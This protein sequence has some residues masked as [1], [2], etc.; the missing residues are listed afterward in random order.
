MEAFGRNIYYKGVGKVSELLKKTVELLETKETCDTGLSK[1]LDNLVNRASSLRGETRSHNFNRKVSQ[2]EMNTEERIDLEANAFARSTR[3]SRAPIGAPPG[4]TKGG[5]S[6]GSPPGRIT[7]DQQASEFTFNVSGETTSTPDR[8]EEVRTEV[9][10]QPATSTRSS[11]TGT[12]LETEGDRSSDSWSNDASYE[13][14]TRASFFIKLA[15]YEARIVEGNDKKRA[16]LNFKYPEGD[17]KTLQE[18]RK[19][20]PDL[21]FVSGELDEFREFDQK[22]Y[23]HNNALQFYDQRIYDLQ[24][25]PETCVEPLE[26]GQA[27][28]W[29]AEPLHA[30]STTHRKRDGYED[31]TQEPI[32]RNGNRR[33]KRRKQKRFAIRKRL[34]REQ[35]ERDHGQQSLDHPEQ[36]LPPCPSQRQQHGTSHQEERSHEE[37]N[38]N[39]TGFHSAT[40]GGASGAPPGCITVERSCSLPLG[41]TQDDQTNAEN[42]YAPQTGNESPTVP[43]TGTTGSTGS[44]GPLTDLPKPTVHLTNEKVSCTEA[45]DTHLPQD[46]ME[47]QA[48][49][50]MFDEAGVGHDAPKIIAENTSI[51]GEDSG[52]HED[53]EINTEEET[54][55]TNGTKMP[56]VYKQDL[57]HLRGRIQLLIFN[58][59]ENSQFN[60]SDAS[61]GETKLRDQEEF[62]DLNSVV[63]IRSTGSH[64][65]E[66][67]RHGQLGAVDFIKTCQVEL[68]CKHVSTVFDPGGT[69]IRPTTPKIEPVHKV[70]PSSS[71]DPV[72]Y[73]KVDIATLDQKSQTEL[74]LRQTNGNFLVQRTQEKPDPSDTGWENL[75]PPAGQQIASPEN[76]HKEEKLYESDHK[77]CLLD[78]ANDPL[79]FGANTESRQGRKFFTECILP[80]HARKDFIRVQIGPSR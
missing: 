14:S 54:C 67:S 70:N 73:V 28:T 8:I 27:E 60:A 25:E 36:F 26:S 43:P 71:I 5:T 69:R 13:E 80:P 40:P 4:C 33:S 22:C 42:L 50:D 45:I 19:A 44:S 11:T 3:T 18:S 55:K 63:N 68:I 1:R 38:Q 72:N 56:K 53:L 29:K 6:H 51:P 59:K 20:F 66:E 24:T 17:C 2:P 7:G 76:R 35:E 57:D 23:E 41:G 21:T 10:H 16:R 65:K 15:N 62:G 74:D 34:T 30:R 64:V 79:S 77:N 52:E 31:E 37:M 47:R 12:N 78:F 32:R 61:V 39:R 48:W 46:E 9:G 75:Y 49:I 58:K